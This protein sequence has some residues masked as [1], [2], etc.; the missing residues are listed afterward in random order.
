MKALLIAALFF[1]VV[2]TANAAEICGND[3]DDDGNGVVDEGCAPTLTTG[4]CESPLS[5]GETGMLSWSTGVLH[6]DLPADVA[7]TVPLGPGIG[8]RRFYTSGF[9]PGAGPSSVNH[10]PLGARWQHTYMSWVDRF[11]VA[12]IY[13]IV[14]HTSEGR[15]VYGTYASTSGGWE[16]YTPQ[17]GYHV[18]SIRRNTVSPNQYQVQ[19]LTGETLYYNSSGQLTQIWDS[20]PTPNKVMVTWTGTTGGNVST[21]TDASGKRRLLFN[22]TSNLLTSVNYQLNISGTWTTQQTTTYAY[23][24]GTITSASIGPSVTQQYAYTSGYLTGITDG[25]G[26]LISSFHYNGTTAAQV[27]RVETPNGVVGME[28]A[29]TRTTCSGKTILYFNKA[30]TGSCNIDS[31]CGTGYLCG[32]KTGTGSTGSCFAAAR[33]LGLSTVNGES[34]VTTVTPLSSAG[35]GV[36]TGACSEVAQYIWATGTTL[37]NAA[38]MQ[39]PLG[40]YTSVSYNANGL[41]QQIA[42]ADSDSDPTNGGSARTTYIAYDTT[43]PGRLAQT[44]RRSDLE[45]TG[46]GCTASISTSCTMETY[47][48]GTDTQLQSVT[49]TGYTLNSAAS[50]VPYSYVTSYTHDTLG[51]LTE[52]DGPVSGMKSTFDFFSSTDP[53]LDGFVQ[54]TK[55]Y[56]DATNHLDTTMSTY[57]AWGN[58]T[59]R[60]DPDGTM[61]CRT[62]D[63]NRNYLTQSREA[64]AGQTDCTTLNSADLTTSWVRD[65][66]LRLTQLTRADGSCLFNVFNASGQLASVKRRDD[67]VA[68]SGGDTRSYT[69]T[70]DGQVSE[71]DTYDSSGTL[72]MKTPYTYYQSRRLKTVVNPVDSTS[73]QVTYDTRG[74]VTQVD[75]EGA[76]GTTKYAVDNDHRVTM[77]T[78]YKTGSTFD[79]W[80]F[81][82]DW[83]NDQTS[84]TDS[85]PTPKTVQSVRDDLGRF[86]KLVLAD[87]S[88]PTVKLYDAAGRMTTTVEAV[89]GSPSYTHSFTFDS[90]ERNVTVD[91]EGDC[92][93]S[94]P[95]IQRWY[96]TLPTGLTCPIAGGCTLLATRL[97]YVKTRLAC[98]SAY[99]DF[100]LDQETFY[101]YDADGRL[102]EEYI[103][104]DSG[105]VADHKYSWTKN[106]ALSQVITPSGVTMSWAYGS[107]LSNSDTD[108]I[109]S[110]AQ[111]GT[112]LAYNIGWFP[113]GRLQSYQQ[114]YTISGISTTTSILRDLAYRITSVGLYAGAVG[115]ADGVS[116]T[117][118]SKGRVT[119]RDYF[120]NASGAQDSYFLYDQEDRV[121]CETTAL[122]SACPG[123]TGATVK[124]DHTATTLPSPQPY[125]NAGDWTGLVRKEAGTSTFEQF[126]IT[127]GTHQL[128]SV[129]A[130]A[131][132]GTISYSYNVLGDR[133]SDAK[134]T[135]VYTNRTYT[136]DARHNVVNVRGRAWIGKAHHFYDLSSTFDDRDRRVSKTFYDETTGLSQQWFFDYDALDRLTEIKYTPNTAVSTTF[137]LFQIA[138]LDQRPIMF[139]QTDYPSVIVGRR[140]TVTDETNRVIALWNWPPT[141]NASKLWAINPN[142]WAYDQPAAVGSTYVQPLVFPGQYFDAETFTVTSA[143]TRYEPA[144]SLNGHRTYDPFTGGYLQVD[145]L[146]DVTRSS[147]LYA[148]SDPVAKSDPSG[149]FENLGCN[150][151]GDGT[152]EPNGGTGDPTECSVQCAFSCEFLGGFLCDCG[153]CQ[154]SSGQSGD[155]ANICSNKS[156]SDAQKAEYC[157]CPHDNS[158]ASP[159]SPT[160]PPV[161]PPRSYP[162]PTE[163]SVSDEQEDWLVYPTLPPHHTNL[164]CEIG[165]VSGPVALAVAL[166][167]L[168]ATKVKNS[169]QK[170]FCEVAA[171]GAG[172]GAVYALNNLMKRLCGQQCDDGWVL[173]KTGSGY[174]CVGP[175]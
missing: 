175:Q 153:A 16:T 114:P 20:L 10:T 155:C 14:L 9:A 151:C 61:S 62:F 146:V 143:G 69:Y 145:P 43:Y 76:L 32:G 64:M 50:P 136:Y 5:C 15:D 26:N 77:E 105:R 80:S 74:V 109:T 60:Q 139:T 110:V 46:A 142:A 166:V 58:A 147:Y 35:A 158:N 165:F 94:T 169:D 157:S 173:T 96:D 57:D 91:Y 148:D 33:C 108:R 21:V 44:R 68:T 54:H 119:T 79:T 23:T 106:G 88:Y 174:V 19:L 12:S 164:F 17:A 41:P 81:G 112:S 149:L 121:L 2:P 97:A 29:S 6:Y 111:A 122:V 66:A 140:Y 90:L 171:L 22:Y 137:S 1:A 87:R 63:A 86:V 101:A 135:D 52:M 144:L 67:C 65:S 11:Q 93:G 38:G 103:R 75:D 161:S 4:V 141:G 150:F 92:G 83:L 8:L 73:K 84:Y 117:L 167:T 115:Q 133:I 30:T 116:L 131:S 134:T 71:V 48:Y 13:R 39:D 24:S 159:V 154:Q 70:S 47:A 168:C 36:C 55:L 25:A 51:R 72:T 42:T 170:A 99:A 28:F 130:G 128:A 37:L 78:R 45:P 40:T 18:M 100:S 82:H 156:Y 125:T 120:D 107:S 123:V 59:S 152:G 118:D 127:S 163:Q 95:E 160:S 129:N 113:F 85:D 3:L 31:D 102:I 56:K 49:Q 7:P 104:D 132:M 53:K 89:G 34:V 124:Y 27:N 126:S 172:A 162:K 98:S 138:W